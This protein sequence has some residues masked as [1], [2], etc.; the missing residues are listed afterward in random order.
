MVHNENQNLNTISTKENTNCCIR[1][2]QNI[3]TVKIHTTRKHGPDIKI[4]F[5]TWKLKCLKL[6]KR[7]EKVFVS[8]LSS[9]NSRSF[10]VLC[11][12]GSLIGGSSVIVAIAEGK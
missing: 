7:K 11:L 8:L 6:S 5:E 3:H 12:G 10:Y 9:S 4:R 2:W 1:I